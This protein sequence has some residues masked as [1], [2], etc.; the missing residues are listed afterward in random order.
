[1]K[2]R[3]SFCNKTLLRKNIARFAPL[4]GIY[5]LCLLIGLG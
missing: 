3:T 1:M 5:L 2:S 4:W